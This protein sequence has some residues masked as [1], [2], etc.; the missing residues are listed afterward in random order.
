M[1]NRKSKRSLKQLVVTIDDKLSFAIYVA[2]ACKMA[3]MAI[4]T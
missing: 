3:N 4:K 2:Y 1:N